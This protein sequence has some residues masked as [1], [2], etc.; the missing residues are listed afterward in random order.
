MI[1]LKILNNLDHSFLCVQHPKL[2]QVFDVEAHTDD[3]DDLD[4]CPHGKMVKIVFLFPL[5][6]FQC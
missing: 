6:Y 5:I 2:N 3:V 4:I 1:S